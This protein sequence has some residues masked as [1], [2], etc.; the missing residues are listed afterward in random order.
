MKQPLIFST[1]II[2]FAQLPSFA[3]TTIYTNSSTGNDVSGTGANA[4]PYRTFNKA[5]TAAAS[6]DTI[7]LSGTF[8]WTD[9]SET[10][11]AGITGYTLAKNITVRGNASSSAIVQ[12]AT[13]ANTADRRVF[14]ISSGY[15][16][17]MLN[18]TIRYGYVNTGVNYDGGGG[19][20][21]S[22]TLILDGCS[23]LQNAT[24]TSTQ[25]GG[26]IFNDI[27]TLTVDNCTISNNS[28]VGYGAGICHGTT[29][30]AYAAGTMTLSNSTI[31]ANTGSQRAGGLM[32]T[33][34]NQTIKI[35][36]CTFYSN[37][38]S[39]YG[40]IFMDRSSATLTNNTIV[41]NT[42]SGAGGGM[43]LYAGT[44]YMK[45]NLLA[46]NLESTS[47]PN[48]FRYQSGT[49]TDN[50]YNLVE[51]SW[52]YS[53]AGTGDITG[54][55][56]NLN[57]STP[58]ATNSSMNG[59]ST[60]ALLSNSV[61]INAG[62]AGINNNVTPALYDQR[63][64]ARNGAVDI[65]AYE[66]NS[67]TIVYRWKGMYGKGWATANNWRN[68]T[69]PSGSYSVAFDPTICFNDLQ[70]DQ[71]RTMGA[72][73]FTT[74]ASRFVLG[75][76]NL[77]AT[78]FANADANSYVQSNGTGVLKMSVANTGSAVF[79]VGNSAYNPVTITNN[80][81]NTDVFSVKVIDEVYLNGTSGTIVSP[82]HVK[83]T[84]DISK[85]TANG[86]S[87]INFV[88]KWNSGE[89]SAGFASASL[90]H[91]NGSIWQK[92]TGTTSLVGNQLTYTGYTGS[93]S[94]FTVADQSATLPLTWGGFTV[95][96]QN[97]QV[98]LNWQTY[99]EQNTKEFAVQHSI[100]GNDWNQ[101]GTVAAAGNSTTL[102]SYQFIHATPAQYMNYYRIAEYDIDGSVN[103]S[104]I[105]SLLFDKNTNMTIM[106]NPVTTG[107]LQLS[108]NT[109]A[110]ITLVND[111]G[112]VLL[113]RHLNEGIQTIN[114][115]S[116]AKGV[117]LL[118]N[119]SETKKIVIQ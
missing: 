29:N 71:D 101:I 86:G 23:V 115:S 59:T 9:A 95:R 8:G 50:G 52:N 44:V 117:Y 104:K 78:S 102:S 69:L 105:V 26:G 91:Y 25:S 39:A 77:T 109:A 10:G 94:P 79:A 87:G 110:A 33:C 98:L 12:A 51:Y 85:T 80:S 67:S 92:Q 48:D 119:G 114:V 65:G 46:N 24:Y 83:R 99:Q 21:N 22:G 41:G 116:F 34:C 7:D 72:I 75:S 106:S 11:D 73:D 100:N 64:Y 42:C 56:T 1:L 70:L 103:Y 58:L 84:W 66:Y 2:L 16:V 36:N 55:Q 89:T 17:Y 18:L 13:A 15:T 90:F 38:T 82:A 20:K 35:T 97:N 47:T 63:S 40:A 76:Y 81:G 49:V 108:L 5:Y 4:A 28:T 113:K 111:K 43:Y 112:Q 96:K 27:G 118:T 60:L 6:G 31:T 19:I 14:T 45:N 93:F 54:N 68:N 53:F 32:V 37:S 74:S 57:I 3:Q 62:D 61:A 30:N 88:F 107:L